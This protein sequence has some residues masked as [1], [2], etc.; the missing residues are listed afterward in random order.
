MKLDQSTGNFSI[1]KAI[2]KKQKAEW[3]DNNIFV[4][5]YGMFVMHIGIFNLFL[6]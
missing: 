1:I 6:N 3:I 5:K 4:T 2:S